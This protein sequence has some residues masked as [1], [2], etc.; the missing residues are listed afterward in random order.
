MVVFAQEIAMV[1]RG[2]FTAATG[3]FIALPTCV[4]LLLGTRDGAAEQLVAS[5]IDNSGGVAYT[6]IERRLATD[7][8]FTELAD[9]PPGVMEFVDPSVSPGATYCYRL[10]AWDTDGA[11]PYSE[12]VC[13]TSTNDRVNVTISKGGTGTGTVVSTP[14]GINC[15]TGCSSSFGAGSVV[16]LTATPEPGSLFAGWSG[17]GC[18]GT[19][20]CSFVGNTS[21]TV[22]ATFTVAPTTASG[23][24]YGHSKKPPRK[25]R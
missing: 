3:L 20:S 15:G 5:W 18:A 13:A 9:A 1:L 21:V 25:L 7:P 8:T 22:T 19:Q 10:F 2:R 24:P 4:L 17:A 16:T 11:S 12:E 23:P 6:R 14:S